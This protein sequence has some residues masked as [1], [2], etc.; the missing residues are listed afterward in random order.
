[1]RLRRY[2]LVVL[3]L[4]T[5]PSGAA[6]QT[7]LNAG[8]IGAPIEP[9]NARVR[10]IGG[11]GP[12]MFDAMLLPGEPGAAIDLVVP[13]V[14]FSLQPVWG[15]YSIGDSGGDLQ[16]TRFP[17]VGL[18]YPLGINSIVMLTFGG[19]FDQRWAVTQNSEAVIGG[20]NVAAEDRFVS[21]GGVSAL[22]VGWVQR[23]TADFGVGVSVGTYTGQV[24]RTFT[25]SFDTLA[26]ANPITDFTEQGRWQFSGPLA[27]VSGVWDPLDIVRVAATV[28]WSGGLKAE[29]VN[30]TEGVARTFDMPLEVRVGASAL[31]SSGLSLHAGVSTADWSSTGKGFDDVRTTGRATSVGVGIQWELARFWAG[32]LPLR[33]GYRKTELP[34]RL[35][36]ED[37]VETVF[38][39]GWSLTLAQVGTIPLAGFDFALEFG[40]RDAGAL[41]ED[42]RRLT[43]TFS[44]AGG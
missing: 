25:R 23:L 27:T 36:E 17:V 37:P 35:G 40:D 26:V 43:V 5:L 1:M 16:A 8:G 7:L 28:A 38:S 34:F 13:T 15:A 32:P 4:S 18:S 12:G 20:E 44:L 31:L 22:R 41:S 42:F 19:V 33:L 11:V 14:T 24:T 30:M 39:V 9:L 2:M 3:A 29:P 10:G 21:D 6:A